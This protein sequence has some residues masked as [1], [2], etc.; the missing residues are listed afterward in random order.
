MIDQTQIEIEST[1]EEREVTHEFTDTK[2]TLKYALSVSDEC[3]IQNENTEFEIMTMKILQLENDKQK[4][5][6]EKAL[7]QNENLTLQ[8]KNTVNEKA[9]DSLNSKIEKQ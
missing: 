9:I 2:V 5:V 4:L 1:V 8:Q 6:E 3:E 7:I